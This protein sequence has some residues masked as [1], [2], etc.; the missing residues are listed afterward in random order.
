MTIVSHYPNVKAKMP[1]SEMFGFEATLKSATGGR[2]FYFLVD[3][4]FETIPRELLEKAVLQIRARKGL[5]QE[6]PRPELG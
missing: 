3:V 4:I 5:S 2:G 1:V 6:M